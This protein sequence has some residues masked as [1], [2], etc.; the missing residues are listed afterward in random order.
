M[1]RYARAAD[2]AGDLHR[3]LAG[4]PIHARPVG[5]AAHGP[6]DACNPL[7]AALVIAL[8]VAVLGGFAG[9]FGQWRRAEALAEQNASERDAAIR[10][11]D[12]ADRNYDRAKRVVENRPSWA[13][14]W[15]IRRE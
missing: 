13:A 10:E 6:L 15:L 7:P 11:R 12:R 3:F 9:V 8:V 4:E 2:L 1:R 14:T 5:R